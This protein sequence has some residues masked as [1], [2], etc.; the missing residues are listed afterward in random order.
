MPDGAGD[1]VATHDTLFDCVA[2]T[3]ADVDTEG[4]LVCAPLADMLGVEATVTDGLV[5]NELTRY[6]QPQSGS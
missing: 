5:V 3:L 6:S 1:G 2:R 4:D